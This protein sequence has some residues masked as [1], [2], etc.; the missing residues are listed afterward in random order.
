LFHREDVN[1]AKG[2]SSPTTT[3]GTPAAT[4]EADHCD[5]VMSVVASKTTKCIGLQLMEKGVASKDHP[6]FHCGPSSEVYKQF[7]DDSVGDLVSNLQPLQDEH[8]TR[9]IETS[10]GAILNDVRRFKLFS[11]PKQD[12]CRGNKDGCSTD[13][14]IGVDSFPSFAGIAAVTYVKKDRSLDRMQP[15]DSCAG[16][17]KKSPSLLDEISV[18]SSMNSSVPS[19]DSMSA[20]YS[21]DEHKMLQRTM[22]REKNII[23]MDCRSPSACSAKSEMTSGSTGTVHHLLGWDVAIPPPLEEDQQQQQQ[24]A[25][26]CNYG[27]VLESAYEDFGIERQLVRETDTNVTQS[28]SSKFGRN[29][30]LLG[31]NFNRDNSGQ[32]IRQN[33][34]DVDEVSLSVASQISN[35]NIESMI[36]INKWCNWFYGDYGDVVD[37]GD[38]DTSK[39]EEVQISGLDK[40]L[41]AIND[42]RLLGD[43]DDELHSEWV[44]AVDDESLTYDCGESITVEEGEEFNVR[45]KSSPPCP[46]EAIVNTDAVKM[47]S[48][49]FVAPNVDNPRSTIKFLTKE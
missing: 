5:H 17:K 19:V 48:V 40:L 47:K 31:G 44:S 23:L 22:C 36:G 42:S 32:V 37:D 6:A 12:R 30:R 18:P 41:D 45:K 1:R 28:K 49:V 14:P 27:N 29:M 35:G 39:G 8:R 10:T 15:H 26:D 2:T 46:N 34:V 11:S 21:Q 43:Y 4:D 33:L 16:R 38:D 3:A 20:I 7:N 13:S 25:R 9:K 24:K